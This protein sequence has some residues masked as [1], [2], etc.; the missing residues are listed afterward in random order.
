MLSIV[1]T[2][3]LAS[4]AGRLGHALKEYTPLFVLEVLNFVV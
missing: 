1:D 2:I 3:L 4:L